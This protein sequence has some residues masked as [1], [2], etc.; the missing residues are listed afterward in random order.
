MIGSN[1]QSIGC[2]YC[3]ASCGLAASAM[4]VTSYTKQSVDPTQFLKQYNQTQS[5]TCGG[6][7]L[8]TLGTTLKKYGV[9]VGGHI[10]FNRIPLTDSLFIQKARS[11]LQNGWTLLTLGYFNGVGHYVWIVGIDDQDRFL[12]Y[13]PYWGTNTPLPFNSKNYTSARIT[14][15][16]PVRK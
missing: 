7:F 13:D 10:P 14:Y 4:I 9:T 15:I 11:Y 5:M 2:S 6:A 12:V 1:G 16:T 3:K 8:P